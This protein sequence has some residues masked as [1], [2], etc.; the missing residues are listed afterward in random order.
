MNIDSRSSLVTNALARRI[1]HHDGR[2]TYTETRT[3]MNKQG[4]IDGTGDGCYTHEYTH[5]L[6]VIGNQIYICDILCLFRVA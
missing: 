2:A 5:K 3:T 6:I 1:V 4:R